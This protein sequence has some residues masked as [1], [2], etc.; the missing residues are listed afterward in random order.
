MNKQIVCTFL[1]VCIIVIIGINCE[2]PAGPPDP[3]NQFFTKIYKPC[4]RKASKMKKGIKD[5]RTDCTLLQSMLV[6]WNTCNDVLKRVKCH[7]KRTILPARIAV[8]YSRNCLN[9]HG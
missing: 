9:K 4:V 6:R 2:S 3:C 8:K 5:W 1:I 7:E